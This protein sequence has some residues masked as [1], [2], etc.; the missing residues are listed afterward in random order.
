M[1]RRGDSHGGTRCGGPGNGD[2]DGTLGSTLNDGR[3]RLLL[4]RRLLLFGRHGRLGRLLSRRPRSARRRGGGRDG[5]LRGRWVRR[6]RVGSRCRLRGR[7][8]RGRL[9][10][11]RSGRGRGRGR[12]RRG[13]R[14]GGCRARS[15]EGRVSIRRFVGDVGLSSGRVR[16]MCVCVCACI[17]CHSQL[18]PLTVTRPFRPSPCQLPLA[19]P[20]PRTA[21]RQRARRDKPRP[22]S[23][24]SKCPRLCLLVLFYRLSCHRRSHNPQPRHNPFPPDRPGPRRARSD[25]A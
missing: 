7:W 2:D 13:G 20:H 4:L 21:D 10:C 9:W 12:S 1:T 25:P 11:G 5:Y 22:P 17:R 19:F 18:P 16:C 6:R 23:S 15:R 8:V 24:R 14:G 3:I